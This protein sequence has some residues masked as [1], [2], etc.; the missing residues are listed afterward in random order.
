MSTS[1][2]VKQA[3][4]DGLMCSQSILKVFGPRYGLSGELAGKIACGLAGGMSW[5]GQ[6]CGAVTGAVMVLGLALCEGTASDELGRQ[7]IQ[8][9]VETFTTRFEEQFGKRSCAELLNME[10]YTPEGY[11]AARQSDLFNRKCPGLLA[12]A[13]AILEDVL[14]EYR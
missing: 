6:V 2:Q 4:A 5:E 9:A 8:E 3:Y 14:A 7:T 10:I 13:A 12:G 1:D 11:D